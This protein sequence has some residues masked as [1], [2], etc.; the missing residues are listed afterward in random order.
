MTAPRR[1]GFSDP[2]DRPDNYPTSGA[3]NTPAEK[4]NALVTVRRCARDDEERHL[5]LLMLGLD[6]A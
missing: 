2:V 4:F 6:Q 3:T 1:T 5:F